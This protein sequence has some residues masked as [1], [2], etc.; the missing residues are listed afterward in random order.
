MWQK[1]THSTVIVTRPRRSECALPMWAKANAGPWGQKSPLRKR[2]R[3]VRARRVR[4]AHRGQN[5]DV[6]SVEAS[7]LAD[8]RR[9]PSEQ[10]GPPLFVCPPPTRL[11]WAHRCSAL[12][13]SSRGRARSSLI[14]TAQGPLTQ[15]LPA[16]SGPGET[17]G[18]MRRQRS[19]SQKC[20]PCGDESRAECRHLADP[21]PG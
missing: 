5:G 20:W 21:Q 12:A 13:T 8:R 7:R 4:F 19:R 1:F 6:S 9:P 10:T 17:S 11:V 2:S 18:R 3:L 16:A 15:R 14:R